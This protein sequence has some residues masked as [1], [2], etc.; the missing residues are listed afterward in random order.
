MSE[1]VVALPGCIPK[2][3][4]SDTNAD[5]IGVLE[6]A[7]VDFKSGK[8]VGLVI[9]A[10]GENDN[11]MRE[12]APTMG[13]AIKLIGLAR[14]MGYAMETKIADASWPDEPA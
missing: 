12:S 13:V 10:T 3:L 9:V 4:E 1:N 6:Q 7:L 2:A 5:A 8:Y 14:V 11:H